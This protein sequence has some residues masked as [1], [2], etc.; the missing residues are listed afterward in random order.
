MQSTTG[1]AIKKRVKSS[2]ALPN[3][4]ISKDTGCGLVTAWFTFVFR[5][6]SAPCGRCLCRFGLT[7]SHGSHPLWALPRLNLRG[8]GGFSF[9]VSPFLCHRARALR[10]RTTILSYLLNCLYY[11]TFGSVC[12]AFISPTSEGL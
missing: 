9:P 3:D 11:S 4:P 6:N 2:L 7:D 8:F 12:Q 5:T 1:R 10:L